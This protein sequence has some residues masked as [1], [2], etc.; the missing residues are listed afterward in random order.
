VAFK[1]ALIERA[2]G[3]ELA[4]AAKPDTAAN[5]R[6]GKTV[7][8]GE[9]PVRIEPMLIPKRER[10]FTGFD[11]FIIARYARDMTMRE[12]QGFLLE[13]CGT[14]VSAESISSV[15]EAVMAEMTAWQGRPLVDKSQRL[16]HKNSDS[17][18][19]CA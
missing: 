3:A 19:Q 11:E 1:K 9:G 2:M 18:A 7:Q 10:R 5:Q 4:G 15:T 17:P 12:I 8:T 6:N 13:S 16:E 14:N